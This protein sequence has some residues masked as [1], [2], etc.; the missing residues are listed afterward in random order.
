[1]AS[2]VDQALKAG[3]TYGQIAEH[4]ARDSGGFDIDAARKAGYSDE[5]LVSFLVG[6][7]DSGQPR[8]SGAPVAGGPEDELRAQRVARARAQS[9]TDRTVDL[10]RNDPARGEPVLDNFTAGFGKSFVDTGRGLKQLGAKAVD[11][12]APREQSIAD[13]VAGRNPSREAAV[14]RDIDEARTLDQP[15]SRTSAGTLG[16]IAGSVAQA[17]PLAVIPGANTIKGAT[18]IGA[19][20]GAI[21]PVATGE[22]RAVNTGVGAVAG[23]A[24]PVIARAAGA[25]WRGGK[26]LAEPFTAGGRDRIAGRTLERFGV[27]PA[28]LAGVSNAPTATGARL[29]LPEQIMRPEGAAAAARMQDSVRAANPQVAAQL[30][31]REGENNAARVA[32]LERLA[33]PR[34]AAAQTRSNVAGS[35]YKQAGAQ[36]IDIAKLPPA[37]QQ[38]FGSLMERPAIKQAAADASQNAANAGKAFDPASVSALHDMKLAIDDR[39]GKLVGAAPTAATG[40]ELAALRKAQS[41]LVSFIEKNSPTYASARSEYARLSKPVNQADVAGEILSRGSANTTDLSGTARLMPN[42]LTGAVRDPAKLIKQATGRDLG[43]NLSDVLEPDQLAAVNAVIG[44]VDRGAA[45]ARAANGPGSA[46]AQRLAGQNIIEQTLSRTG[47]PASAAN[48][49]TLQEALVRPL[50]FLYK[51]A[52]EPQLQLTLGEVLLNPAAAN[53]VM[54]A[55]SAPQRAAFAKVI[56][57]PLLKQAARAA[58]PAAAQANRR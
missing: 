3:Y 38:A 55:M 57:N 19:L 24:G 45:V 22:S 14:T 5:Q 15:L 16:N 56:S 52:A 39:I 12:V 58:L 18:A 20:M 7:N 13:I 28:D 50:S 8:T 23:A 36:T 43:A 9:D 25:V 49:V 40:S 44:E 21:Q 53:R 41:S 42:S 11:L 27:T 54:A 6:R 2:P 1:M 46:T 30:A 48:S 47:L 29:T 37:E 34:D 31:A 51:G 10:V 26:A 35:L 32:T 17:V 33:A 4:L